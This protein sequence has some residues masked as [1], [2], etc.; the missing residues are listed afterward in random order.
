[1]IVAISNKPLAR[2]HDARS[3]L[4]LAAACVAG[5]ALIWALAELVPATRF[6]DA[7]V[8]YDAGRLD[9]P[10]VE[11]MSVALLSL[12]APPLFVL[13]GALLVGL[14][15]LR[16]RWW[17]ALA[18]AIVLA[19]APLSAELL[20]PLL[21]HSHDWVG[22][23][24]LRVASWP[25]GHTTAATALALCA[26]LVAPRRLRRPAAV[27]AAAFALAVGA[28]LVVLARHMPSD[29]LG[30]YL[31]ATLWVAGAVAILRL[32][33]RARPAELPGG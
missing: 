26:V 32:S 23:R 14:A 21:P 17:L 5:M 11:S 18:V 29:V 22:P 33:A 4:L 12:L 16:G 6:K 31:L 7:V 28:A 1:V 25:S 30:G 10:L 19:L 20:K 15:G 2:R 24:H 13:W 8:L 3:A 27:V 9:R